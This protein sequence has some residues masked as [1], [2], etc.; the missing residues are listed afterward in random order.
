MDKIKVLFAGTGDAFASGGRYHT[1]FHVESKDTTLL[2]DCGATALNSLIKFC[3]DPSNIDIIMISHFHGDHIAGIPFIMIYLQIMTER[4]KPLIICGPEGVEEKIK[5]LSNILYPG[6]ADSKLEVVYKE[7]KANETLNIEKIKLTPYK[8]IHSEETKPHALKIE[9][10]GRIISYS[11][12]TEWTDTLNEAADNA[13]LFICECNFYD[14]KIKGHNDYEILQ[15]KKPSLKC[16]RMIITHMDEKMQEMCAVLPD[17]E[18][19]E[20]GKVIYL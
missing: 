5:S 12:D 11:G 9:I 6:I 16:K 2:I 3:V 7:Y 13:D 17:I 4:S 20:D 15:K 14:E 8:V 19:A 1:C 10:D 18:Q